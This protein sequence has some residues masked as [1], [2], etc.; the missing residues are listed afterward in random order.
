MGRKRRLSQAKARALDP[1]HFRAKEIPFQDHP[2]VAQ[3][4]NAHGRE[5]EKPEVTLLAVLDFGSARTEFFVLN[6]QLG[7][8]GDHI[9]RLRNQPLNAEPRPF[10]AI[11]RESGSVS[12]IC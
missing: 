5:V 10:V 4:E 1:E 12:D 3:S 2:V 6:F 11:D 8:S 7:S 9:L